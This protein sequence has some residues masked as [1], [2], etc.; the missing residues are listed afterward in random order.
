V[1]GGSTPKDSSSVPHRP[2]STSAGMSGYRMDTGGLIQRL[3]EFVAL[4]SEFPANLCR[5]HSSA[6][7]HALRRTAGWA[8]KSKLNECNS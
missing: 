6:Y 8:V 3:N 2:F 5:N 7:V 4:S 1:C